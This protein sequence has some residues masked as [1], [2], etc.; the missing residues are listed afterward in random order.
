M[1]LTISTVREKPS[2]NG[3]Y[4]FVEFTDG[5]K[6]SCWDEKLWP[7]LKPG[8]VGEVKTQKS[9]K[10]TNL[11]GFKVKKEVDLNAYNSNMSLWR[12]SCDIVAALVHGMG[13]TG[14]RLVDLQE[15]TKILLTEIF[16][17]GKSL[18]FEDENGTEGDEPVPPKDTDEPFPPARDGDE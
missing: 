12:G 5:Q 6:M 15:E 16:K 1:E 10:F 3:P 17:T 9:G 11:L 18:V 14:A 8:A 4:Q 13:A 2:K 7:L